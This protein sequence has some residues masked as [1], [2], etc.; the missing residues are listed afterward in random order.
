MELLSELRE[1]TASNTRPKNE[2]HFLVVMIK[3]THEEPL[4][5]AKQTMSKQVKIAGY[6]LTGYNGIFS[7]TKKE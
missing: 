6:I 7:V 1:Q 4:S 2:E 5:Q 3:S